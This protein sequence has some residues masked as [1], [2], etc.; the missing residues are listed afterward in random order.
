M[1]PGD[2]SERPEQVRTVTVPLERVLGSRAFADGVRD[3]REGRPARFDY[4]DRAGAWDYERGRQ[5]ASL[6]P[7]SLPLRVGRR[8]N[9]AALKILED[10]F[11]RGE[12]V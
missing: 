12:I 7:L 5:W 4:V 10:A 3:V 11:S 9:P 6:A 8:L 2:G 1:T